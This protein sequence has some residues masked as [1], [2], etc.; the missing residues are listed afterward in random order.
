MDVHH[1]PAQYTDAAP[2]ADGQ[3]NGQLVFRPKAK[4]QEKRFQLI[5]QYILSKMLH[6]V[7]SMGLLKASLDSG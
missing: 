3:L 4:M 2:Q 1:P 5:I 6:A 7:I